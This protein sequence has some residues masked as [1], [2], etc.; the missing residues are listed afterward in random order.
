VCIQSIPKVPH[1]NFVWAEV[2]EKMFSNQY[3][4]MRVYLKLVMIMGSE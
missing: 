1:E 2:G 4:G 3:L